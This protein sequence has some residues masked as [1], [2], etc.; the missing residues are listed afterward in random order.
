[1]QFLV[2]G[3]DGTDDKAMERRLAVRNDHMK[4]VEVMKNEGRHLYACA[5]LDEDERMVGSA[6][7]VDFPTREAL[8]GWLKVEPYVV[9]DVWR[10]I[11]V[12]P[13]KVPPMFMDLHK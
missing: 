5:L 1:M 13:C 10:K 12:T 11:E 4:L 3:Y 9:G 6:L 8:D 7:I 2:M